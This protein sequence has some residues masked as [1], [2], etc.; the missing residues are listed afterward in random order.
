MTHPFVSVVIPCLN[1]EAYISRFLDSVLAQ[2]YPEDRVEVLVVD[3]MSGDSTRNILAEYSVKFP[4][5]RMLDNPGRITPKALNIGIRAAKGDYI[6]RMDAHAVYPRNYISACVSVITESGADNVG[7]PIRTLPKETGLAADSISCVLASPFGVGNSS[8]RTGSG[9]PKWVDTVFGGFYRKS[10]FNKVGYF[11]E[12]LSSSQDMEFNKRLAK[13]GGRILLHP[14]ISSTYYTRASL[15]SFFRNNFR[16]GFWAIYPLKF[17]RHLP[18]SLRHLIPL[19][20]VLWLIAAAA[21]LFFSNW[22]IILLLSGGLPYCCGAVF[23]A[24]RASFENRRPAFILTMPP[25]FAS[26]HVLYGLGSIAASFRL[27][28]EGRNQ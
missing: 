9:T 11:N 12:H 15:V 21:M 13:A 14:S 27:L 5:M 2:D 26:L 3:G 22:G 16:N 10:V 7:G 19:F 18:V 1:E 25:L 23:F 20:F 6:C 28:M 24:A 4:R 8:F 17:T